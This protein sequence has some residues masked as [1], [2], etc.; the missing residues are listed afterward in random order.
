MTS[1][2]VSDILDP[3]KFRGAETRQRAAGALMM[4]PSLAHAQHELWSPWMQRLELQLRATTTNSINS[5]HFLRS[6][7]GQS[8][9]QGR[10]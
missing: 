7:I 9:S 1:F 3:T 4:Q 6:A 5:L 8:A 2:S 10:F